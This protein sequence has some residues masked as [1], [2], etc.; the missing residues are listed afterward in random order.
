MSKK[1]AKVMRLWGEGVSDL[2]LIAKRI[3]FEGAA[4]TAGIEKVKKILIT[5][6]VK[7]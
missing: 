5:N 2:R 7:I 6:G 3:G 1:E 4:I